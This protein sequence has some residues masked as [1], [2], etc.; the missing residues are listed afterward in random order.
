MS[1][2]PVRHVGADVVLDVAPILG[3]GVTWDD[4]E[5]VV[6]WVDIERGELHRFDPASGRDE[7]VDVGRSV[8]AIG[9]RDGGGLVLATNA[10][11]VLLD[12][13]GREEGVVAA[14]LAEG[15]R[16]NDGKPGPDGRFGPGRWRTTR[17]RAR[18]ACCASTPT[19]RSSSSSTG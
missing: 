11:F 15:V 6:R 16:M 4:R 18:R 5:G 2:E 12:E 10:G 1:A 14:G 17:R 13:A 8:S 9:L 19:G 3:E 7:S